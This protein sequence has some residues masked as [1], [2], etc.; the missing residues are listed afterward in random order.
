MTRPVGAPGGGSNDL[1]SVVVSTRPYAAIDLIPMLMKH[2][3]TSVE[4]HR[5]DAL[6]FVQHLQPDLVV[7]VVDPTRG[8]DLELLGNLSRASKAVLFVIAATNDA[9]A[10][11]LRAGAD[12]YG[13]DT[14]GTEVLDAQIASLGRRL[15]LAKGGGEEEDVT[16]GDI[17]INRPTRRAWVQGQPL[18]LTNMEFSL[19][20]ALL[21][22]QGR[23]LSPVQAA[24]YI[25][26][27][28]VS[29]A[30]AMQTIKV[31]IR[32][33]RQKLEE[34]G[35]PPS[36]IVNVRGRGYMLDV[37]AEEQRQVGL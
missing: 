29:E 5:S 14:D 10:A 37:A 35:Y 12:I 33:H 3:F 25:S 30:E 7:A 24:R 27:R 26:G 6:A 34:A 17:H 11:S 13:R 31:Y 15:S 22:E 19:L 28:V 21:E 2:G 1:V 23:V 8:E 32:R 18:L 9:L 36:V 20:L 16:A 4:R